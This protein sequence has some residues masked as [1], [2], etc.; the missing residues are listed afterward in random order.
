MLLKGLTESSNK[1]LCNILAKTIEAIRTD[2]KTKLQSALRVFRTTPQKTTK[3]ILFQ[4]LYGQ[5]AAMSG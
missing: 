4:M 2:W 1:I 3:L 5:K